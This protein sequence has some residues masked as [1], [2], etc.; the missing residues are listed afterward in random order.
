MNK[1]VIYVDVEDDITA[2]IGKVK[3]AKEPIV[4]LVPPKR[5]GV[6]QSAVNLRILS[7][8]AKVAK[9]RLVLITNDQ[10]LIALASS[11]A[12]PI[13]KNLQS[14]PEVPEIPALKVDDD[15][16]IIDG[17]QL[18]VGDHADSVTPKSKGDIP[19]DDINIDDDEPVKSAA[20]AKPPE[21][22]AVPA[23]PKN[24]QKVPNFNKFRKK[25]IIIGVLLVALIAFLYWALVIAPHATVV[26]SAKTH[27]E[28]INTSAQLS[29]TVR[30][31]AAKGII[32]SIVVED[33]RDSS[34]DFM[35]TGTKEEGEAA[36]G[37]MTISRSVPGDKDVPMGTG[38][39]NGDCTFVTTK[40]VS[41]PGA[42]PGPWNGSGYSVVSGSVD[43]SV[44]A[45]DIGD[46][47]NLSERSY[48][49][50]VNGVSAKGSDMKG[51]A[52]RTLK[53]VTQADVQKASAELVKK[54]ND[55]EKNKL[56]AKFGK[57]VMV[58]D[59]S[60]NAAQAEVTA[61]PEVGE[62]A[63]S[64][65]AKL[66][67]SITYSMTGIETA[68]LKGYLTSAL[69]DKLS[70]ETSQRV[71]DAGEQKA[72]LNEFAANDKGATIT[73]VATGQVGPQIDDNNVKN[74]VKGKQFGDIQSDLQSISG[75]RD[76]QVNFFPF[77]VK[78]VPND[79]ERISIKFNLQDNDK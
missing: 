79:S 70:K 14:K 19:L 44:K 11:V 46:Q 28:S 38:F 25:L 7:R 60:F 23:R 31:D 51:G 71:Y 40:A 50:T 63:A 30:T 37:T 17:S 33:K 21:K 22:G 10:S 13:A 67:T 15:D 29:P 32:K 64:G 8:V 4:A 2:I 35:A 3:E 12:L 49:P 47:C 62:E 59:A 43:V 72:Q 74:R 45:T 27:E 52:K 73:I 36:S 16:D 75:V 5:I 6:L 77:W 20:F 57:G 42:S 76:V 69:E 41:V 24:V 54:N 34:V 68:E 39:S 61:S 66:S 1:D 58:I 48:D 53:I 9:K 78:T 65:K 56:R 55:D 26:I 18:P